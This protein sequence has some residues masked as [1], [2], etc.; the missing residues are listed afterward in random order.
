MKLI[1]ESEYNRFMKLSGLNDQGFLSDQKEPTHKLDKN[2]IL[3][4]DS[5]P[6]DMKLILYQDMARRMYQKKHVDSKKPLL[7]ET[8]TSAKQTADT[9][10]LKITLPLILQ[11]VSHEHAKAIA[12]HMMEKGV[13]WDAH[14][15]I[16]IGDQRIPGSSIIELLNALTSKRFT[17]LDIPGM[18]DVVN[19][20][21]Q[22]G[23]PFNLFSRK[24]QEKYRNPTAVPITPERGRAPSRSPSGTKRR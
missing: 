5:I 6:D 3:G 15:E 10:I 22:F 20:F 18:S 4:L 17:R 19:L 14:M 2:E 16:A 8:V 7:V 1:S 9:S 21:P 23:Q 11:Q 12:E 24:V 13:S